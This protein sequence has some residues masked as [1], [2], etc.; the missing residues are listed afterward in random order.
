MSGPAPHRPGPDLPPPPRPQGL[1]QPAVVHAGVVRTAGMTPRRDG[2]LQYTGQVGDDLTTDEGRRAA[3]LAAANALAA[4]VDAAGGVEDVD[5]ILTMTVWVAAAAGFTEHTAV[6][7]GASS[8]L[9][10]ALGGPPPA[11]AALGVTSLPGGAAVE[12]TLV[13]AL[14]TGEAD[15][16]AGV[17]L[18]ADEPR[19]GYGITLRVSVGTATTATHELASAVG[20]CG[21]VL[22]ALDVVEPGG[23]QLTIDVSCDVHD[24]EHM[25]A[26]ADHLDHLAGV[27]VRSVSD[28]TFLSHLGGKLAVAPGCQSST[29]TTSRASTPPA[30]PASPRPSAATRPTPTT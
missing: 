16:A 4:V 13:A 3:A 29:A 14:R 11:R 24:E 25:R 9:A 26:V 19:P 21:A 18:V 8:L 7:D 27:E 1:Y 6:A 12:V 10:D 5:R 20:G 22:T 23:N 28:R 2:V 17:R 15:P 30:S